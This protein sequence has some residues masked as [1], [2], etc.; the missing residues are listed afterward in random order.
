MKKCVYF[1]QNLS[2]CFKNICSVFFT[3]Y[4]IPICSCDSSFASFFLP[5]SRVQSLSKQHPQFHSPQLLQAL[6]LFAT[7]QLSHDRNASVFPDFL[8][9]YCQLTVSPG[10]LVS[11]Y[12][13][14]LGCSK[15]RNTRRSKG[16]YYK[17]YKNNT[18][19]DI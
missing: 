17:T 15:Q 12:I 4:R 19:Y 8:P 10:Y 6:Q 18:D 2:C 14:V 3:E 5:D 7:M 16:K 9:I 11:N 13:N 1:V